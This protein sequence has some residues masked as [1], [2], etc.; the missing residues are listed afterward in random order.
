MDH[1]TYRELAAGAA[2]DD[3]DPTERASL[4]AH[5]AACAPC[6]ADARA[7]VD[8]AGMLAYAV[9]RRTP[10]ASLRG[11]V[12]AAIATSE[13]RPVGISAASLAYAG[14]TMA[15]SIV[16]PAGPSQARPRGLEPALP[17]APAAVAPAAPASVGANGDVIELATLRRERTRYRRLS[18][19]GL[20]VAAALAVAVGALGT[21]AAGMSAEL[22][23]ATLERD[24]A[25]AQLATTDDAM[26]VA[27]APGHATATL[28]PDPL[29]GE[30]TVYVVYLPGTTDAWLMAGNLPPTPDGKV[31]QLWSADAD[32]VHALTTFTCADTQTCLAPFGVDL[33]TAKATM[34]TL[35]PAGGAQGEPG[36]QVAFGELEG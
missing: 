35:E 25:V 11:S 6:R 4:D 27:L 36:P 3:L 33:A 28:T 14:G 24:A 29:A 10:P 20:A 17:G 21:T 18:V 12:L 30:A 2:L 8:T 9:P 22:E 7:L 23:T 1:G 19:A 34:V 13:N 31:Y 32:G 15:G 5:I 26:A 16:A